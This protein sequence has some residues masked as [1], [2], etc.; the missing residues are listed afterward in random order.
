[1]FF[2]E[3]AVRALVKE[4]SQQ[5]NLQDDNSRHNISRGSKSVKGP[6]RYSDTSHITSTNLPDKHNV[7]GEIERPRKNEQFLT[8]PSETANPI[9]K[10]LSRSMESLD[11][12]LKEL[13]DVIAK[14]PNW[15]SPPPFIVKP[16]STSLWSLNTPEDSFNFNAKSP[17]LIISDSGSRLRYYFIMFLKLFCYM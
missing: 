5:A 17:S 1:M 14:E 13:S 8:V 12:I 9:S 11:N 10:R 2:V 3:I 4:F 15:S 6:V 7:H 16:V